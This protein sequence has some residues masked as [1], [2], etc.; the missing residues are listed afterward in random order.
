MKSRLAFFA[1][2][3]GLVGNVSAAA[4]VPCYEA[5]RL[6]NTKAALVHYFT[7]VNAHSCKN[8]AQSDIYVTHSPDKDGGKELIEFFIKCDQEYPVMGKIYWFEESCM[9]AAGPAYFSSAE[10][11]K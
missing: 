8:A 9:P 11:V 5:D 3:L 6:T 7:K 10:Q 1:V 4:V 2:I